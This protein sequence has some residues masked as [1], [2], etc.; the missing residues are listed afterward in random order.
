MTVRGGWG[1]PARTM[2][3]GPGIPVP[4]AVA[5]LI[6]ANTGLYLLQLLTGSWLIVNFGLVPALVGEGEL[7]RLFTYQFL[8]GGLVHLGLNMFM[9]WMFG[10]ELERRWGSSFFVKYYFV[11]SV[12]GG[13]LFTLVRWGTW[14]P[15]IGASGGI[16]GILMAYALWFPDRRVF[17]WFLFPIKVRYLVIFLIALEALQAIESTGTGVA[18][19]AHLGGM[20]F[21]YAYL[22]WYGVGAGRLVPPRVRVEELR[23]SWRRWRLRRLQRRRMGRGPTLH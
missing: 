18:H 17:V 1:A 20:G 19:A 9:L 10:S 12:G 2:Q 15:S 13:I 3:F 8:H 4:L 14:I 7:W 6:A 5:R 11:C 22:R 16:Y 21:G 23:R